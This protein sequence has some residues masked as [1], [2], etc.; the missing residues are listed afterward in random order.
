MHLIIYF[1]TNIFSITAYVSELQEVGD[2]PLLAGKEAQNS[3]PQFNN[4]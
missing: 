3:L 1:V 4:T 2:S